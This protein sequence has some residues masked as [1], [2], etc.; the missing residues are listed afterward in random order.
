[1]IGRISLNSSSFL[2]HCLNLSKRVKKYYK[3]RTPFIQIKGKEST[4]LF[5]QSLI[6][7]KMKTPQ[8]KELQIDV[9]GKISLVLVRCS[10]TNEESLAAAFR[11]SRQNRQ[12]TGS[13]IQ[14][15]TVP[16]ECGH[17]GFWTFGSSQIVDLCAYSFC[18]TG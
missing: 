15:F 4:Y 9:G 17:L 7:S 10:A 1:M 5:G 16:S 18:L 3:K 2:N 14:S 13:R 11:N 6:I 8:R 12:N